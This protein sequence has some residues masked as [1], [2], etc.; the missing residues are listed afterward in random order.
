METESASKPAALFS[1]YSGRIFLTVSIGWII[2]RLGRS[3]LPLSV[4]SIIAEMSL[5]PSTVGVALTLGWG[6]YA[7][8]QYP[9]GQLSDRLSHRTVLMGGLCML[10]VGYLLLMESSTYL[11]FVVAVLC[12]GRVPDSTS[13]RVAHY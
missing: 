8:L 2:I 12:V 5:T 9:S 7:L 11:T 1:G 6:I 10:V 3:L 13:S 4:P